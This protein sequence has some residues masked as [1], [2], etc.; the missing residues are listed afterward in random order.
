M[1]TTALLYLLACDPLPP[2]T[3]KVREWLAGTQA[4]RSEP[5]FETTVPGDG[6]KAVPYKNA[7]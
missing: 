5:S 6:L 2:T 4:A 7:M 3:G 1:L